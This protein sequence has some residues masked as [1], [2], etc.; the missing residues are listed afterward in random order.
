MHKI[1]T[2]DGYILTVFRIPGRQGETVQ[3]ALAHNYP[4]LLYIHGVLVII[5]NIYI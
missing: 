3:E 4:T 5:Y 2:E 1:T